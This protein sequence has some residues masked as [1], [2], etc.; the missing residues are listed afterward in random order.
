MAAKNSAAIDSSVSRREMKFSSIQGWSRT[1][2]AASENRKATASTDPQ[3]RMPP[4]VGVPLLPA[5][6]FAMIGALASSRICLPSFRSLRRRVTAGVKSIATAKAAVATT[7]MAMA[8]FISEVQQDG[9]EGDEAQ[10]ADEQERERHDERAG[11]PVLLV[12]PDGKPGVERE[13]QEAERG[14]AQQLPRRADPVD[15]EIDAVVKGEERAGLEARDH[16]PE[17]QDPGQE[18]DP[19]R[20]EERDAHVARFAKVQAVALEEAAEHIGCHRT[21]K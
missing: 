15:A 1:T 8:E 11:Q 14:Q 7:R 18:V 21:P 16:E 13:D 19:R 9:Q 5:W 3:I 20:Q 2:L 17:R 6:S 10:Q 12:M 4:M